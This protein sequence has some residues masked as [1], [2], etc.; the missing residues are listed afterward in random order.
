MGGTQGE[1][2]GSQVLCIMLPVLAP[3]GLLRRSAKMQRHHSLHRSPQDLDILATK[4][5]CSLLCIWFLV[6][7]TLVEHDST[8]R[9]KSSEPNLDNT[10]LSGG[11]S[12]SRPIW[13]G[14]VTHKVVALRDSTSPKVLT[15][16]QLEASPPSQRPR[17]AAMCFSFIHRPH[18]SKYQM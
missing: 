7:G 2:R 6:P 1:L 13:S 17:Q 14:P 5:Q 9:S 11:S 8:L 3:K 15:L 12:W 18:Y 10:P 16:P 4:A